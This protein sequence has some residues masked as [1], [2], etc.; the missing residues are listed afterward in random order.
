MFVTNGVELHS[1]KRS[2]EFGIWGAVVWWGWSNCPFGNWVITANSSFLEG[3]AGG[4]CGAVTATTTRTTWPQGSSPVEAYS[5]HG[6]Q[7]GV[8]V[9]AGHRWVFIIAASLCVAWGVAVTAALA[10]PVP[11]EAAGGRGRRSSR[12]FAHLAV[13]ALEVFFLGLHVGLAGELALLCLWLILAVAAVALPLWW[14]WTGAVILAEAKH[15]G[16]PIGDATGLARFAIRLAITRDPAVHAAARGAEGRMEAGARGR[17]AGGP[18]ASSAGAAGGRGSAGGA[19]ASASSSAAGAAGHQQ[20]R[21]AGAPGG[22]GGAGTGA[23]LPPRP[24]SRGGRPPSLQMQLSHQQH[25]VASSPHRQASGGDLSNRRLALRSPQPEASPTR[26]L[27]CPICMLYYDRLYTT[28][29]CRQHVCDDCADSYCATRGAPGPGR[30][31]LAVPMPPNCPCPHCREIGFAFVPVLETDS[32]YRH[33]EDSP[34]FVKKFNGGAAMS[35][36]RVG[37]SYEA[38]RRKMVLFDGPTP[39]QQQHL[40]PSHNS[41]RTPSP[42]RGPEG[43]GADGRGGLSA[44]SLPSGRPPRV[45]GLPAVGLAGGGASSNRSSHRSSARDAVDGREGAAAARTPSPSRRPIPISPLNLTPSPSP[46][47]MP[48]RMQ[49]YDDVI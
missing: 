45:P 1:L 37:D 19:A 10:S 32:S 16:L 42:Y 46:N 41:F 7:Q 23:R 35:P 24:P 40:S 17:G 30:M 14:D 6:V 36:L 13:F 28:S 38:M 27:F 5:V 25:L 31:P 21:A 39:Q 3:G 12:L 34:T 44:R 47:R 43:Y 18:G 9:L 2:K 29:C 4:V 22:G 49:A 33:Y 15:D 26:K 20:R 8:V 11:G 48:R